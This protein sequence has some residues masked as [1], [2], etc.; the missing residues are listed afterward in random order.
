MP[1][2][3]PTLVPVPGKAFTFTDAAFPGVRIFFGL[4]LT[5][6]LLVVGDP[7]G[8]RAEFLAALAG[9][10][11]SY[12]FEDQTVLAGP[13]YAATFTGSGLPI[14]ATI[15]QIGALS[16]VLSIRDSN[17]SGRFNTTPGGS[18]FLRTGAIEL[19]GVGTQA[20]AI[21]TDRPVAAFG[22]Y[23]TDIADF[24]ATS[25]IEFRRPGGAVVSTMVPIAANTTN[26]NLAFWG[27]IDTT[28]GTFE[29][30][31]FS[32]DYAS[33]NPGTID[34]FGF[35]DFIVADAGQVI[36]VNPPAPAPPSYP[37]TARPF[38]S[39]DVKSAAGIQ[40]QPLGMRAPPPRRR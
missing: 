2:V 4:N 36:P 6:S 21:T 32:T 17:T 37:G 1:A 20:W 18:K 8:A 33:A 39:R 40:L 7:V 29:Q 14:V 16:G 22:F 9:T 23:A 5:P 15:A 12:G 31:K 10:A 25:L 26:E 34:Y 27:V 30:I 35:D 13:P 38:I 11:Q 24:L 3:F 28:G 19:T